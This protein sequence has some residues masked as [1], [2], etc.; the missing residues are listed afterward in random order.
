MINVALSHDVDRIKKTY[1]Y[2]THS[3]KA[4][5]RL[6]FQQLKYQAQ[7]IYVKDPYWM[8]PKIIQIEQDL[9]VKST[10]FILNETMRFRIRD[11]KDWQLSLGRYHI[12][13]PKLVETIRWLDQNGWE[14]GVHGSYYSYKDEELLY[15][16][17]KELE[18]ILG[19]EIIG[20]RQ[21]YLN[22]NKTTWKIQREIGFKYDS[23]W[24]FTKNIG[25]RDGK[26]KPFTPF[27][28]K[29]IVFPM[30]IMDICFINDKNRWKKFYQIVEEIHNKEGILILN[31]HQRVFNEKEFPGFTENYIK[32]IEKLI[33]LNANFYTIGEYFKK[34][35]IF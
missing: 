12:R 23:T 22:I 25:F 33:N 29:F 32:I 3:A 21:H 26:V 20:T 2:L 18:D 6:D 14:I 27:N 8:F 17:K 5:A 1:Q 28:D 19:H 30:N 24:G 9:G 15:K 11:Y 31:W 13:D 35:Y 7:S 10:F 34:H 4:I 16:E